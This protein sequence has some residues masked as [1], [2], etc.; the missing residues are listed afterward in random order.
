M[1]VR[2]ICPAS[3]GE[4]LQGRIGESEKLISYPIDLYATATLWESKTPT[5]SSSRKKAVLAMHK[6]IAYYGEPLKIGENLSLEIESSIPIAKGMAS[7]TADIA[8]TIVATAKLLGKNIEGDELG[9]L[10]VQIEPTDSTIFPALT[11]FDHLKGI[12]IES[13]DWIPRINVLVLESDQLLDTQDFRKNDYYKERLEN[14]SKIEEAYSIFKKACD[15]QNVLEL[16]KAAIL[17]ALTNQNILPKEKLEDIIQIAL[18][19]GCCGVNV[20][21][22]GTVLGILFDKT[23]VDEEILRRK[24]LEKGV[25]KRYPRDYVTQIVAGG[26]KIIEND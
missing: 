4:L 26:V 9:K 3:C 5:A 18:D 8:A 17:S 10:C 13:F 1:R 25:Y 23:K 21:H 14:Q 15:T 20:A 11:L 6:T 2:A 7:S 16:G 22:S 12:R 24:L 19:E